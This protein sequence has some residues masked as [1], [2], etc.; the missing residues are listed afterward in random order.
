MTRTPA[1][2]RTMRCYKVALLAHYL[3]AWN[4]TQ[5]SVFFCADQCDWC[6]PVPLAPGIFMV[7]HLRGSKCIPPA[8]AHESGISQAR[9][10]M[11]GARP[12][13]RTSPRVGGPRKPWV[14][15]MAK[16]R[17]AAPSWASSPRPTARYTS[18]PGV[19]PAGL[20]CESSP[21]NHGR[22]LLRAQRGTHGIGH[23]LLALFTMPER[24]GQDQVPCSTPARA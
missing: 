16:R 24:A 13:P 21:T 11:S 3:H 23:F 8:Q 10:Q 2:R 14:L 5:M 15:G 20:S 18:W 4:P 22:P 7:R 17:Q 19:E 6:L 12:G 1:S 9:G